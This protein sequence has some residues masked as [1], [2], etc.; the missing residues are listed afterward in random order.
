MHAALIEGTGAG[1]AVLDTD[2]RFVY[3]N[4]ALARLNGVPADAHLGRT[5]AEVVPG[6]DAGLGTLRQVLA[7][8]RTRELVSSGQTRAD[9]PHRLRVWRGSYHRLEDAQGRVHGI[10]VVVLE[11]SDDREARAEL[12][13]AR[14]RLQLLDTA[15]VR[16]G[17]TLEVDRTCQELC[18]LLVEVIADVATVELLAM[19]GT[20]GRR[21][22]ATGM[23]RLRRAALASVP[24]LRD[25]VQ[26]FGVPGEHVEYQPGSA[27]PRCLENGRPL[28]YNVPGDAEMGRS[29]PNTGR[30]SAYRAA[31][32]HSALVVPLAARGAQLGTVTMV[33]AGSSPA[34]GEEDVAVAVALADR[35]AISMDNARRYSREHGIAVELQRAL[36]ATPG[37]GSQPQLDVATRYLPSGASDLVG[38]D[39]YDTFALPGGVTLLA[40]GDVM[41]HGV[42]AAVEMSHYRS[43]LRVVAG[44]GD[45]PDVILGRM[46][47]LLTAAGTERPATCLL[48]LA[49]PEHGCCRFANAGHLPPALV[50]PHGR[51][52]LLEVPPGPPLGADL[53]GTYEGVYV[54]WPAGDTLLLYTD[55]LV[56]RR[57]EDIDASLARLAGMVL[58]HAA[59]PLDTLLAR[60]VHRLAPEA[61]E[62]DV[63]L[64]AARARPYGAAP[65]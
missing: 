64:L 30:V 50:D 32:I 22:P 35:A 46:D 63:A 11:V 65:G 40:M 42:E 24:G 14:E 54:R 57:G 27:I 37:G 34:F 44:D 17:R 4:P 38:G 49:D 13:R 55:G 5:I 41:G 10:G 59:G 43:L 36:L 31:G 56:E 58:P 60:V 29:A 19:N 8:G 47:A 23:L 7:D 51:I 16:I 6:V 33:R 12:E 20:D 21:P 39:W 26:Q 18:D 15:A 45:P 2:L 3:V 28:A 9:S 62:D 52:R 53:G 1:V 61:A 25:A 48:A